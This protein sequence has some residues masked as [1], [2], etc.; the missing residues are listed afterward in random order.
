MKV[1]RFF[2]HYHKASQAM[3]VHFRGR[4][5]PCKNI[6]CNVAT[7]SKWNKQQPRLVMQGYASMV[8]EENGTVTIQ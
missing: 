5:I 8:V 3:T 7:E 4:C 2:Y 1:Y 6:V